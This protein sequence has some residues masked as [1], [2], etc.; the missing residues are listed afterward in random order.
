MPWQRQNALGFGVPIDVVGA[1]V[2]GQE[3]PVVFKPLLDSV[4][5][6]LHGADTCTSTSLAQPPLGG[7]AWPPGLLCSRVCRHRG[8]A[9][10]THFGAKDKHG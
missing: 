8:V 3:P 7:A 5:V 10:S 1:A 9:N 4:S 2:A 6:G